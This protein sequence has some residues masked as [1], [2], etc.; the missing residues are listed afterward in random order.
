SSFAPLRRRHRDEREFAGEYQNAL[1][2]PPRERAPLIDREAARAQRIELQILLK[3][4]E[5]REPL[6]RGV[7]TP[8]VGAAV[9]AAHECRELGDQ[10]R[11]RR[12]GRVEG[13]LCHPI[14]PSFWARSAAGPMAL[15]RTREGARP[16]GPRPARALWPGR[17]PGRA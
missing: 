9:L 7:D 14:P 10:P 4:A 3:P 15:R 8:P 1:G 11:E 2:V 16:W 5:Q 17:F 6:G 12:A 13:E